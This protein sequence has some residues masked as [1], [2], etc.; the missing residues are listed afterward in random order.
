[1]KLR[2]GVENKGLLGFLV[3]RPRNKQAMACLLVIPKIYI[4]RRK[5]GYPVKGYS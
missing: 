4:S 1:L 2:A 3:I 5:R